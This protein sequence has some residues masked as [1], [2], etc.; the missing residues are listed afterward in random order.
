MDNKK[1]KTIYPI[2]DYLGNRWSPRAFESRPV[3][4]EKL[5]SLFEAARWAPSASNLQPWHFIIGFK[6]D[7]TY[8]KI[9]DTM[10]EFNQIWAKTAPVL[11]LTV[12]KITIDDTD[13]PNG[14]YKYDLGQSVAHITFQAMH[15]GLYVH[16]MTGF[17]RL[18]AEQSFGIPANF[19]AVSLISIGYQGDYKI[20]PE[21]MQ[22]SEKAVRIR[23]ELDTFVFSEKFGQTSK[24]I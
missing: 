11:V 6:G 1:A 21:R 22:K 7:H 19:E 12:S 13:N 4:K 9:Y 15:E 17:D 10:V 20:L 3:E 5:L 8:Q 18:K 24:L 14:T 23:K 16:Q 2:H